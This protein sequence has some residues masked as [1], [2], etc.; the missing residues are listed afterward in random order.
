MIGFN[1][2]D[3]QA[4]LRSELTTVTV[5]FALGALHRSGPAQ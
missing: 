2:S 4:P 1:W 3:T 5:V